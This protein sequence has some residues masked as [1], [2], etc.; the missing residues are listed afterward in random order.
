MVE[1]SNIDA[2]IELILREARARAGQD[3]VFHT[4]RVCMEIQTRIMEVMDKAGEEERRKKE[5]ESKNL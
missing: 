1:I 4:Y 2:I 5:Y 3:I